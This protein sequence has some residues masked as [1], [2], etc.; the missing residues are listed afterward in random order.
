M[1]LA[2]TILAAAGKFK[3]EKV[4]IPEWGTDVWIRE[5]K[6]GERDRIEGQQMTANGM[7]KYINFR[8][9]VLVATLCDEQGARLFTDDQVEALA[10]LP[11]SGVDRA[12]DVACRVNRLSESDVES[13]EKNSE[14]TQH[15]G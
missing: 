7:A 1:G 10:A 8:S 3:L 12:F 5:L 14:K 15:A 9:R 4:S 6:A 11:A 2:E 13:L